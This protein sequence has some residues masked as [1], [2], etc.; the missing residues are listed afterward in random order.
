M[1]ESTIKSRLI[2]FLDYKR[3]SKTDFGK[4][5]GVS[6]AFVT[7]IR[8]SI[9]P[10]KLQSIASTFPDLN[11]NWLMTGDGEMLN[12]SDKTSTINGEPVIELIK[13][14]SEQRK[15]NQKSQEQIDRLL[16]II[17][18]LTSK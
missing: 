3:V 4:S 11:I 10:D 7:S 16:T 5:I 12:V 2:D 8:K 15:I 13:E 6:N 1:D 14:L 17:E 18:K 9:Q